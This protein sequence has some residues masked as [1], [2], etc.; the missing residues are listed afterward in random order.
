MAYKYHKETFDRIPEEKRLHIINTAIREFANKGFNNANINVI[1]QKAGVSV[2]SLYKYFDTKENL[3]LTATHYGVSQLEEAL[4]EINS[5]DLS[6]FDKIESLLRV[7]QKHAKKHPDLHRLYNEM[8]S[9]SN[10]ELVGKIS[11]DMETVSSIAYS[12][13]IRAAGREGVISSDID[14][15]AFAWCLD[16]LLLSFHFSYACDYYRE[17]LKIYAGDDIFE[18]DEYLIKQTMRFIRGAFSSVSG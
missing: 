3:F 6:F 8:T 15:H 11:R 7:V 12:S 9:E 17:R 4:E 16:N 5:T 1:A 13:F 2:G 14:E 18:R 10:S